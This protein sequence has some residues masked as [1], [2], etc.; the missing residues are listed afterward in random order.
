MEEVAEALTR[1]PGPRPQGPGFA[2]GSRLW[3]PSLLLPGA[4]DLTFLRFKTAAV[5]L[6][7]RATCGPL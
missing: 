7:T 2:A 1:P 6:L 5:P 4:L 3:N